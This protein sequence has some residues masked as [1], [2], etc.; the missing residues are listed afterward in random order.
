VSW[1]SPSSNTGIAFSISTCEWALLTLNGTVYAAPPPYPP[2]PSPLLERVVY[3]H[4]TSLTTHCPGGPAGQDVPS[5]FGWLDE[6]GGACL[7]SADGGGTVGGDPGNGMSAACK[8]A[9][10]AAKAGRQPVF[11]PVFDAVTGTGSGTQYHVRG[12]AA[13]VLTGWSVPGSRNERS[14]LTG[15]VPC[16][17]S[18]SCISGY[19]TT[20]VLAREAALGG[21]DLGASAVRPIP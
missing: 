7:T 18:D 11:I 16:T 10:D 21:P 15:R 17:G 6:N 14:W 13:F 4:T 12:F 9:F 2:N 20:G 8:V 19:F 1:G 3:L 5:G